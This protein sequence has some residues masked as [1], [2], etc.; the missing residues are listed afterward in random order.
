VH[1]VCFKESQ[2]IKAVRGANSVKRRWQ[3]MLQVCWFSLHLQVM[4]FSINMS[5]WLPDFDCQSLS[6]VEHTGCLP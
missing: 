3:A 1:F 2:Q 4:L 6:S 5:E